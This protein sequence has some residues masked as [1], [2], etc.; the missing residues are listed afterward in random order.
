MIARRSLVLYV[1]ILL[2]V[3]SSSVGLGVSGPASE[4]SR[5]TAQT[6]PLPTF[7]RPT[8]SGIQG[9]GFEPA[10]RVDPA[11]RIYTTSPNTLSSGTSWIWISRDGG[12][13]FKWIPASAPT[14]GKLPTCAG[15]GDSEI[16]VDS[17]GRLYH[18][19]LTLANF[20]VA[21]SDNQG[22]TFTPPNCI[23]VV[24]TAVDR[25]WY[26]TDGDATAGG[27]VYLAHNTIGQ[28][29]PNC[30]TGFE[31]NN[32]LVIARSPAGG[33]GATAGVLFAPEKVISGP[34]DEGIMGNVE[35]SPTT[36]KI[37]VI[38][39][40][41]DLNRILI[42]RC[43]TV[44]FTS[45]PTGLSCVDLQVAN[46][47][48]QKTGANF[49]SLAID[50]AGNLFAI[51]QAAPINA[52]GDVIGDT[53]LYWSSS[54]TEGNSWTPPV[55]IPT[56]GLRNNI[57]TW[58]A[59]GDSGR[60]NIA[61]YGTGTPQNPADPTCGHATAFGGPD[62]AEGNWSLYMTQT[63][64]GTD[65]NP[66]FTPP[67]LASEHH[68]A[69]SSAFTLI[70]GQ[71]GDRIELG[72]FFQMRTGTQGEAII[73]FSDANN[74]A[75]TVGP[76]NMFVR[77]NGG[78]S[79]SAA[80]PIV[81]GDPAPTNFSTDPTGDATFEA[82]GVTGPNQPNMDIISSRVSKLSDP[83]RYRIRMVV[84]DL[85]SLAPNPTSLNG[86]R[87]LVWSTQWIVPAANDPNGGRNFHVY[88][89]SFNGGAPQFFV[90][91]NAVNLNGGGILQTY[92]GSAQVTGSYVPAAPG[93][94]TI[95]VPASSVTVPNRL[96]GDRL[97][98]VT[99]STMTLQAPANSA[100]VLGSIGGLPFN[101]VDVAPAY[102]FRV[103][104]RAQSI[105]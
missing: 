17:A 97:F 77:Q 61:W 49:P 50:K 47:P 38:H 98:S 23:A 59:A 102:D 16:D 1:L 52:A 57:F 72:D 92:P 29:N 104:S 45:D 36:H 22:R 46:L 64:N 7:G 19:D 54:T 13:T 101:L 32:Q 88:M 70:G 62:S 33:V 99:A 65:P 100:P 24:N 74:R 25:Q 48:G 79:L 86:D 20:S 66:T 31:P 27:N 103:M 12:K 10:I 11:G 60:V 53:L 91:Q 37:Y 5:A 82:N 93:I 71:C 63:L 9:W 39:D 40:N 68:V 21:R 26:A 4:V 43:Q 2:G 78:S 94:V 73:A 80:N 6:P 84:A 85:T 42:G 75:S 3:V 15:G 95:D 56:P 51:W 83:A 67:I 87:N 58:A 105:P 14:Q 44:P 55:Q 28:G 76:H 90:G 41:D 81:N 34:C 35:V 69:H 96:F 89:E 8:I 18:N 30:S